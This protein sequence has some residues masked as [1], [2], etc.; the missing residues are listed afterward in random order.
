[1]SGSISAL[2]VIGLLYWYSLPLVTLSSYSNLAL[3]ET[4]KLVNIAHKIINLLF[5]RNRK[6]ILGVFL[7][8]FLQ[9][10]KQEMCQ[11]T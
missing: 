2:L 9:R 7:N 8:S 3:T 5:M 11:T 1:M 4:F 10:N 6:T